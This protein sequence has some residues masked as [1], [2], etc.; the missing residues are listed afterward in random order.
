L[1]EDAIPSSGFGCFNNEELSET[2]AHRGTKH[3][4]YPPLG[5]FGK[6]V[7]FSFISAP[8]FTP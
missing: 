3:V 6:Q 5:A 4:L 2:N 8:A 7:T 1:R